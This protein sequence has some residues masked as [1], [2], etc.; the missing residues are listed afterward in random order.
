MQIII[1]PHGNVGTTCHKCWP[2]LADCGHG[3]LKHTCL[4]C[5][6]ASPIEL[7]DLVIEGELMKMLPRVQ[8]PFVAEIQAPATPGGEPEGGTCPHGERAAACQK[9]HPNA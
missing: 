2:Q 4:V 3:Y 7:G 5:T 6:P 8:V 9:C 1:C